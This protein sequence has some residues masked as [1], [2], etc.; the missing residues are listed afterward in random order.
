MERLAAGPYVTL[1]RKT[2]GQ[3]NKYRAQ[4]GIHVWGSAA[5]IYCVS[6]QTEHLLGHNPWQE[7]LHLGPGNLFQHHV[8]RGVK[9]SET[10]SRIVVD[11][12]RGRGNGE[13]FNGWVQGFSLR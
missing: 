4:S 13:L 6:G 3:G 9:F 2:K 7:R 5:W 8:R 12:G 10:W 11:N 1:F